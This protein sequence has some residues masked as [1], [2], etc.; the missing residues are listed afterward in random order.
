[1]SGFVGH[2]GGVVRYLSQQICDW[3]SRDHTQSLVRIHVE[4]T[5]MRRSRGQRYLQTPSGKL[6]PRTQ[7]AV[8][9]EW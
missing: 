8:G 6:R 9:T 5:S 4:G 2:L 1:M 3:M 7:I